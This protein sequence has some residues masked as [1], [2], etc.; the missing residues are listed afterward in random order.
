MKKLTD[1]ELADEMQYKLQMFWTSYSVKGNNYKEKYDT[2]DE[3]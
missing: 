3:K 2:G 1:K